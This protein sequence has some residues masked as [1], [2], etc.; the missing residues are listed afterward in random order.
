[1]GKRDSLYIEQY[2][3]I[4]LDNS[5]EVIVYSNLSDLPEYIRDSCSNTYIHVYWYDNATKARD[6]LVLELLSDV[7]D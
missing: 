3:S 5:G 7:W 1:M 6:A 2:H 4:L